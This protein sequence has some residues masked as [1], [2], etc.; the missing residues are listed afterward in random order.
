M[1]SKKVGFIKKER[2]KPDTSR[3]ETTGVKAYM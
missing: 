2:K 1:I 3:M